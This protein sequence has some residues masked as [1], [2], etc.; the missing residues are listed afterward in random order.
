M[1]FAVL[2]LAIGL[3]PSCLASPINFLATDGAVLYRADS[4]GANLGTVTMG[5]QVQSLTRLP[6]GFS[7]PGA[8]G[9]DIIACARN[10]TSG[11]YSLYRL[12]DPFGT[13]TLVSI[14]STVT[15]IG[16]LVFANSEMWGVEDS[17][18]PMRIYKLDPLTGN[19]L[20]FYNLGV[21][22]SGGG[23]LAYSQSENKFY[24]TDATNNRLY[25]W[26]PGGSP[27]LIGSIGFG[28]S[29]NGIEFL[30]GVLYGALRRDSPGNQMSLGYF[31]TNTG[32]FTT[33]AT[34]TGIAGNGTGF[35]AVPEPGSMLALGMGVITLLRR[36][37]RVSTF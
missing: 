14:G 23:G 20:G 22:A 25:S 26:I 19:S 31:N 37:R 4:S 32:A 2:C 7:L 35:V 12:D 15:G 27:T 24:F 18:N 21:A 28:F 30:N 5:A 17:L 34:L 9:G 10:A 3:G 36:K 8:S 1:K 6:L 13:A 11:R 16:S 33:Q 29:N